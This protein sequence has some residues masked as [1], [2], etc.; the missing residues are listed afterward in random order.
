MKIELA[1]LVQ[2]PVI[3]LPSRVA[4]PVCVRL[5][6]SW[7]EALIGSSALSAVISCY[8]LCSEPRN[9]SNVEA[10]R[11]WKVDPVRCYLIMCGSAAN[12]LKFTWLDVMRAFATVM[13]EWNSRMISIVGFTYRA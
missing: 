11:V 4:H 7:P 3:H 10:Q 2:S 5:R 8:G 1:Y 6:G 9:G 13:G 12:P